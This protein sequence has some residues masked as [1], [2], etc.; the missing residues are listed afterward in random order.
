MR[1]TKIVRDRRNGRIYP[2]ELLND[3]DALARETMRAHGIDPDGPEL[4]T[5][6]GIAKRSGL[7]NWQAFKRSKL[8]LR[9]WLGY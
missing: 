6:G 4:Y 9:V 7:T 1:Q 3:P 8:S 2:V 5:L